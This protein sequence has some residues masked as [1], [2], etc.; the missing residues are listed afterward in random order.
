MKIYTKNQSHG[1]EIESILGRIFGH[2]AY[3]NGDLR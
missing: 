3:V 2:A 1:E